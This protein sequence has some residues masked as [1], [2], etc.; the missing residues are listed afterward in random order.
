MGK[1]VLSLVITSLLI[2]T[3]IAS[4]LINAEVPNEVV[5]YGDVSV[6]YFRPF[7]GGQVFRVVVKNVSG[8]GYPTILSIYMWMP[9]GSI[10]EL[11]IY[12]GRG[13][14]DVDINKVLQVFSVWRNYLIS[15]G[16]NPSLIRL[17][18]IIMGSIHTPQGVYAVMKAVPIG[19]SEILSG[20][21]IEID[22]TEELTKK[23]PIIT[24]E[25][26]Q[27]E[28]NTF[29]KENQGGVNIASWPP[30]DIWEGCSCWSRV[31]VCYVWRL[32]ETYA[33]ALNKGAP[34][35]S[36][37]VFGYADKLRS[38]K[39]LE[40]FRTYS[41]AGITIGFTILAVIQNAYGGV[42]F[43]VPGF[44]IEL[45]GDGHTWLDYQKYFIQGEDFTDDAILS[46]G[47]KGDFAFAKYELH[48][49]TCYLSYCYEEPTGDVANMTLAR[50][51]IE[52]NKIKEWYEVDDNP[53]DYNGV[54]ESTFRV[55]RNYWKLSDE[56]YEDI[57]WLTIKHTDIIQDTQTI[58]LFAASLSVLPWLLSNPITAPIA[59]ILGITVGLTSESSQYMSLEA[60]IVLKYEYKGTYEI[61]ARYFYTPVK[62]EY[63]YNKY[64]VGSLYIDAFITKA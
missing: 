54:A 53:T 37:Y 10:K 62:F 42:S 60:N 16:N 49:I 22:I 24:P 2:L 58:P 50:P 27:K 20:T 6:K 23:N 28:L 4:V 63:D 61:Q 36:T 45:G 29:N 41:S 26:I 38:V 31:C 13:V 21:S 17:G 30:S 40:E 19:I 35:V 7:L 47:M 56:V 15:K 32:Q 34:L 1:K 48:K 14:V 55:I 52:N 5:I 3:V 9:D 51:I 44:T 11:G 43:S 8:D 18:I 59:F 25:E 57:Y 39:L 64:Y 12:G 33:V 46:I